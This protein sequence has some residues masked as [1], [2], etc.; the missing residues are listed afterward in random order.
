MNPLILLSANINRGYINLKITLQ[1]I[2]ILV[3]FL[4]FTLSWGF[5]HYILMSVSV[6][7]NECIL[8]KKYIKYIFEK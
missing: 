8:K 2:G 4:I 6:L 7:N 3:I 1:I 5:C